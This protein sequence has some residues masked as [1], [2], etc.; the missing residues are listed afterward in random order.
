MW[1]KLA[2]SEHY[3]KRRN[4]IFLNFSA[5]FNTQSLTPTSFLGILI[6][7]ALTS[8][9]I[10]AFVWLSFTLFEPTSASCSYSSNKAQ[11]GCCGTSARQDDFVQSV[12][13]SVAFLST[14]ANAKQ[15]VD[16]RVIAITT[17][18]IMTVNTVTCIFFSLLLFRSLRS[19]DRT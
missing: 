10:A 5:D 7:M 6:A 16:S 18:T 13:T 9:S 11:G 3:Q 1:Q 2:Q 12:V 14:T 4:W 15:S 8:Q 17:T 19:G